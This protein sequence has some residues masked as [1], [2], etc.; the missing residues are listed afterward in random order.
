MKT[1]LFRI[2][3]EG[4]P[5]IP[6]DDTPVSAETATS[7]PTIEVKGPLSDVY[8]KALDIA[9]AKEDPNG[10][11]V[12]NASEAATDEAAAEA[13]PAPQEAA[14]DNTS[15]TAVVETTD[16][17]TDQ[18]V[19]ESA[20]A[21]VYPAVESAAN[22]VLAAQ[23]AAAVVHTPEPV[24]N[25]TLTVYGVN[26]NDID[27]GT[28]VDMTKELANHDNPTD[29]VLIVD[30]TQP[31]PNGEAASA[32]EERIEAITDAMECMVEAFGGRTFPS[33]EAFKESLKK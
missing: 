1:N 24:A 8:A 4:E 10:D 23:A 27:E 18:P 14:P 11:A 2:A 16:N 21:E 6:Q 26:K 33:L 7:E 15:E 32:P 19:M 22:D 20:T 5:V 9:Y 29:F 12:D 28:V 13:A 3:L 17:G 31:G 25:T 30:G